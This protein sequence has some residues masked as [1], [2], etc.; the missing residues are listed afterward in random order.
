MN[1]TKKHDKLIES[2]SGKPLG[3]NTPENV[4]LHLDEICEFV[5]VPLHLRILARLGLK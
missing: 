2:S 4:I 1:W 5:R 3:L